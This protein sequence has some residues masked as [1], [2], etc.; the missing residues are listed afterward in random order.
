MTRRRP[1][2][3]GRGHRAGCRVVL[4]GPALVPDSV[5]GRCGGTVQGRLVGRAVHAAPGTGYP[6]RG[7]RRRRRAD[8]GKTLEFGEHRKVDVGLTYGSSRARD[9]AGTESQVEL[10]PNRRRRVVAR[11][12]RG[13]FRR[14][15]RRGL[16]HGPIPRRRRRGRRARCIARQLRCRGEPRHGGRGGWTGREDG[17][18]QHRGCRRVVALWDGRRRGLRRARARTGIGTAGARRRA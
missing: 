11:A 3:H 5:S 13:H 1:P 7:P 8:G 6:R 14:P 9:V 10:R 18:C 4:V 17:C 12:R 16:G 15:E 2:G